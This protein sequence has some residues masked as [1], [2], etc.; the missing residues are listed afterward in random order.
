MD[1]AVE[2]VEEEVEYE[3]SDSTLALMYE[4]NTGPDICVG[5]D[6]DPANAPLLPMPTVV[7]P[8][9]LGSGEQRHCRFHAAEDVHQHRLSSQGRREATL[10]EGIL[11]R[12]KFQPPGRV[13]REKGLEV[14]PP[15]G[16]QV[17][18]VQLGDAAVLG[19]HPGEV[20]AAEQQ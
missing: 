7:P 2:D 9:P 19:H 6:T 16:D 12:Y 4:D 13:A 17:Y 14:V 3:P 1:M 11:E 20:R 15:E 8:P 10:L 18:C 5:M